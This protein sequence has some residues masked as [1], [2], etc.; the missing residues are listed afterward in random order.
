MVASYFFSHYFMPDFCSRLLHKKW[1]ESVLF[2]T[3]SRSSIVCI[4]DYFWMYLTFPKACIVFSFSSMTLTWV[5]ALNNTFLNYLIIANIFQKH[6]TGKESSYLCFGY[7]ALH[8]SSFQGVPQL[9]RLPLIS[10]EEN[11]SYLLT[12]FSLLLRVYD[13]GLASQV[14]LSQIWIRIVLPLSF[15]H[16]SFWR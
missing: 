8:P 16:T 14:Y 10:A 11:A 3:I 4:I 2:L 13:S 7:L 15:S 6:G 12:S 5:L 9:R 1:V